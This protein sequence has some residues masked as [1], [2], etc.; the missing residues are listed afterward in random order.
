LSGSADLLSQIEKLH[1]RVIDLSLGR[2]ERLLA[3]MDHPERRLP[4]VI[5]VAGTNGKGSVIAFMRAI[6]QA[7][8]YRV[9]VFNS[10]HL[11]EFRERIRLS[12]G[13]IDEARLTEILR[14][15][16]EAN[17]GQEMTFFEFITAAAFLAYAE[18]RQGDVLLLETGLGGRLDSTNMVDQ[19]AATVITPISMDHMAFLGHSIPEIAAEKAGI[20]K[21]GVPAIFA[22]QR[23]EAAK[24]LTACADELSAPV[25][26][27]GQDF[28]IDVETGVF[29]DAG[30]E[31]AILRLGLPGAHQWGNAAVAVATL[32]TLR[33][34]SF[35]DDQIVQGLQSAEWPARLQPLCWRGKPNLP[36][37]LDGGHNQ[38]AAGAMADWLRSENARDPRQTH[39]VLGLLDNRDPGDFLSAFADLPVAVHAVPIEGHAAHAPEVI[40]R[41]AEDLGLTARVADTVPAALKNLPATDRALIC[42][43]LYLAGTVLADED[44]GAVQTN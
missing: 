13:L 21:P 9:Q 39:L 16:H 30:G 4:P 43:S 14:R 5:H 18:D 42:G 12:D 40:V 36:I 17:A 7:A 20:L 28:S 33:G 41:A 10:P 34:F 31:V 11:V 35:T 29:R 1:P 32:R 25:I 24:V 44:F 26:R 2:M 8:G 22:E 6:L 3:A 38:A 19:P 15:T 37:T 27:A 23:D